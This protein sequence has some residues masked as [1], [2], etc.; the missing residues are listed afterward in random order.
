[1][2]R[3]RLCVESLEQRDMPA[4]FGIPWANPTSLTVSFA[5]DGADVDGQQS[6]LSALMARSGLSESVWKLQIQR[7]FQA[8]SSKA[9]INIA[10]VSDD[11]SA[12]GAQGLEQ[13]DAR[14]GDIRIFAVP[15]SSNVLAIT[16]PPGDLGGTRTGDIILNS[17]YN[18]GVGTW[19]Q[20]DLFTVLLQESGHALGIGNSPSTSSAM[21]EFYQGT[22]SGLSAED[23][24]RIV[25]LYGTRPNATWEP[26]TGNNSKAAATALPSAANVATYGDI[27]NA[28]DADWYSFVAPS[29][30]SA[31][32]QL[33]VA[34]SSLLGAQL[35]VFNASGTVIAS[36][37]A[38]RPGQD[39]T[40]RFTQLAPGVRYFVRID[41][42]A[43]T[44]F[45]SGQYRLRIVDSE[46]AP[47]IVTL[48]GLPPID[49]ANTNESFLT[50]T[51]LGNVAA[52]GHTAYQTFARLRA[53]VDVDVYRVR[54]PFPGMNQ[55]CILTATVR[56]FGDI[57]PQVTVTNA[58][59]LPLASRL[60]AD[61][62]GLYTVQVENVAANA[63]YHIAVRSRTDST[64]DYELR[65]SFRTQVS[66]AH[67]VASGLLSI[68]NPKQVGRID[69]T[70]S[71]QL[72]F[73]LSA[74][75]TPIIGPSVVLKVYDASN[76]VRFQLL[77]QA[78]DQV[79]GVALLGPGSYRVE[80]SGNGSLLPFVLSGFSLKMALLTDPT[81]VSPSDPNDPG[82]SG[83]P[84]PPPSDD[85]PPPPP[86]SGYGYYNDSGF[87]VWGEQTPTSTP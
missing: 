20:R 63:D 48:A 46:Q 43:G 61:G 59:G 55:T 66:S 44:Q 15:M 32:V 23:I 77:A 52:D 84:P 67:E 9:N 40:L 31:N 29:D 80:I 72:Y 81:G 39:L 36:A 57:A 86:P 41:E 7:A 64:G 16:T 21:Y 3:A 11:G 79:D 34:G 1:M 47:E 27:A 62:R 82:D 45:S 24:S 10:V 65:V 49:D 74:L 58:L 12:L 71:A 83:Q 18:F 8:W 33:Q 75:L 37:R 70:G 5:P 17:N 19:A 42:V 30:R 38:F 54:A 85:P 50:A 14:F 13:A 69:V 87:Y 25:D 2:R 78:G 76:R 35:Y 28:S 60:I 56:A 68:L 53:D 51:R 73:Q 6:E 26:S 4:Q 22:R